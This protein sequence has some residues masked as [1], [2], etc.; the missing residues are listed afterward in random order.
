MGK[1]C[2]VN[3]KFYPECFCLGTLNIDT[4]CIYVVN[5]F[6]LQADC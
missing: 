2:V 6:M 1:F 3:F 5:S 4:L